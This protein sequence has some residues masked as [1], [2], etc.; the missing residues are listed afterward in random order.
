[1][2]FLD[3]KTLSKLI[4][5][6]P[7]ALP[8]ALDLVTQVAQALDAA[9]RAGVVHRDLK[10]DNVIV[11]ERAGQP[12][13]KLV[14]FGVAKVVAPQDGKLTTHGMIIGTPQYIAPEQAA[15]LAVDARADV[16]ALGLMLYELLTG[17]PPLTGATPALVM[18]AHISQPAPP[19]PSRLPT[20]LRALVARMLAKRPEERPQS[21]AEVL[22]ALAA[23]PRA[24]S[25]RR[26]TALAL[27]AAGVALAAVAAVTFTRAP[28][29]AGST[30]PGPTLPASGAPAAPP[31]PHVDL[32]VPPA[33]VVPSH[34]ASPPA[35]PSAVV[36]PAPV[37][38]AAAAGSEAA[39]AGRAP[40]RKATGPRR[41]PKAPVPALLP[42]DGL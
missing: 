4:D 3:G 39:D 7:V 1:M 23:V 21:M 30:E 35:P 18:S 41:P 28:A 32:A 36:P 38:P 19:L 8:L 2:E 26:P 33:P 24:P 5:D 29:P 15:G 9:H 40:A 22:A 13:V 10:P 12:F 31:P 14:D 6:G 25:R 37:P 34:V 27:A 17:A 16:Y 20:P 42:A 11:L